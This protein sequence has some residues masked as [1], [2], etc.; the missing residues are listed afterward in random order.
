M[1]RLLIDGSDN[2][3]CIRRRNYPQ[4]PVMKIL[5]IGSHIMI[6]L[7][8]F[9]YI[10]SFRS[11]VMSTNKVNTYPEI[12]HHDYTVGLWLYHFIQKPINK[13]NQYL[14]KLHT[15][16]DRIPGCTGFELLLCTRRRGT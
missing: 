6:I 12:T 15:D 14:P 13:R 3:P 8:L 2:W 9:S 10:I 7:L 1:N 4:K 16:H 5:A 11:C